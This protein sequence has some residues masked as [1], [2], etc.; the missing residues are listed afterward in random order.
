MA[1]EQRI[2]MPNGNTARTSTKRRFVVLSR[3][4]SP[5]KRSDNEQTIT[6]FVHRRRLNGF[7]GDLIWDTV[8]NELRES[9]TVY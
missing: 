2:K 3:G 9:A 7:T 6:Q 8:R 1:R 4:G 5:I